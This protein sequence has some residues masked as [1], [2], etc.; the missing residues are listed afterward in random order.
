M[1]VKDYVMTLLVTI[2]A[3]VVLLTL[4]ILSPSF[5]N[6]ILSVLVIAW[7]SSFI[8][9]AYY[10]YKHK[11]MITKYE[12]NPIIRRFNAND[13]LSIGFAVVFAVEVAVILLL[14]FLFAMIGLA[15]ALVMLAII[16]LL[17]FF[18]SVRTV[19]SNSSSN[20]SNRLFSD[21]DR[22]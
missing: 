8:L 21:G 20:N 1:L 5:Y 9:D 2:T 14:L 12:S 4:V 7:L 11:D 10:T 17:A 13:R 6:I 18:T 3:S 16:H 19:G 22:E 15:V